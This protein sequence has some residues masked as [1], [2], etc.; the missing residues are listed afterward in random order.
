MRSNLQNGRLSSGTGR[1]RPF[2]VR[3]GSTKTNSA[4]NI[5]DENTPPPL[6]THVQP[7]ALPPLSK[8][9]QHHHTRYI[10]R[11]RGAP[12]NV[13]DTARASQEQDAA[14][15]ENRVVQNAVHRGF[16][17]NA[18]T[19]ASSTRTNTQQTPTLSPRLSRRRNKAWE[20][21]EIAASDSRRDTKEGHMPM[22]VSQDVRVSY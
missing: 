14:G 16:G 8:K 18:P 5:N 1:R 13:Q 10:K 3:S 19:V 20:G 21:A 2:G 17:R 11:S 15:S 22:H 12:L 6:P 7:Q 9:K 4:E